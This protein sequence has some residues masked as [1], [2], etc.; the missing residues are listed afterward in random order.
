MEQIFGENEMREESVY[1]EERSLLVE[2]E[3][4]RGY[5]EVERKIDELRKHFV[6][7]REKFDN[8]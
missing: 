1:E 7:I 3:R 8:S 6:Q 2:L 4:L 5:N